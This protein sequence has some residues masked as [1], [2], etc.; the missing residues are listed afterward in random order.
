MGV[1]IYSTWYQVRRFS[2][3][4]PGQD[5]CK[6]FLRETN[7]VKERIGQNT[8]RKR[9]EKD[10]AVI[11]EYFDNLLTEIEGLAATRIINLDK[12]NLQDD[13]GKQK[14]VF[15]RGWKY[16]EMLN[17]SKAAISIVFWHCIW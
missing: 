4:T 13:P 8:K 11:D 12:T 3:N 6:F 14:L 10:C 17:S 7:H 1:S 5:W 15:K 2:N 16:P 9:A